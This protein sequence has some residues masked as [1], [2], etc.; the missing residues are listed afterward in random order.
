MEGLFEADLA[1]RMLARQIVIEAARV[2]MDSKVMLTSL[3]KEMERLPSQDW[4]RHQIVRERF[5]LVARCIGGIIFMPFGVYLVMIMAAFILGAFSS[6]TVLTRF[7]NQTY[8]A[9][10]SQHLCICIP[11]KLLEFPL[12]QFLGAPQNY[13][14]SEL[15]CAARL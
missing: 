15:V 12:V 5:E 8:A 6:T 7:M 10:V 4:Q 2:N 13:L 3:V 9:A 14:F 11:V 1:K